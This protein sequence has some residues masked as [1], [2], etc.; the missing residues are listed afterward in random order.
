ML[1]GL[2]V[3]IKPW[4]AFATAENDAPVRGWARVVDNREGSLDGRRA[5]VEEL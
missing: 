3:S 4:R 5:K 1:S 2:V